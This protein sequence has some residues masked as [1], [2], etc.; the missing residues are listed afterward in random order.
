VAPYDASGRSISSAGDV[1]GDGVDDLLIG[2]PDA[3]PGGREDAGEAYLIFGKAG[4]LGDINLATLTPDA[5][6]KIS[7]AG[8][9][10]ATGSSVR[11]AGDI[12][13]DGYADIVIGAPHFSA[14]T[15]ESGQ[16]HVIYGRDFTG[17]VT[18]SGTDG[19]DAIAG[20]AADDS[21]VGGLD[22]DTLTGGGGVDSFQGGAGDD[23]IHVG[24]GSFRKVDGGNGADTLHLDFGDLV[25]LGNIDGDA[26][27]ADQAKIQNVE[28]IDTDNGTSN[29]IT[30]RLADVLRID[31]DDHAV[32]GVAGL[33]N[34]L[35][36]DGDGS[37]TLSLDPA[38]GWSAPD[39][40]TLAGYAIY[41][42]G[43]VKIAVDLDITVAVA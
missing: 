34:V 29:Q 25:D 1:N 4:G 24:D 13:G 35:K 18:H 14:I 19:N 20:T 31:A 39:T 5:G 9:D 22:N 21:F 23:A 43:N 41:A 16:A 42:A 33:D 11:A 15:S 6:L 30:L 10:D 3:D 40:A 26:V 7:G 37:D 27:T 17:S 2:A 38:D 8:E 12:N 28:T 32:G 36:L